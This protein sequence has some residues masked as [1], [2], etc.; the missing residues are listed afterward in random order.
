MKKFGLLPVLG[1][2]LLLI[3]F[4]ILPAHAGQPPITVQDIV[5]LEQMWA[6]AVSRPDIP[7]LEKLLSD[8][9][10]YVHASGNLETKIQFINSLKSGDRKYL[11]LILEDLHVR[12]FNDAAVVTGRYNLKLVSKGREIANVNR[13]IHVYVRV[14]D[15]LRLVA[16]QA[17]NVPPPK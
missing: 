4:L 12:V 5:L 9:V 14:G 17:T 6:D 16:H 2:I 15:T 7:A 1:C 10:T 3:S 13:Y 11:P 8:N